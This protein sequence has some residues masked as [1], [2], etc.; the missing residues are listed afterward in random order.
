[1]V[2]SGIC[3]QNAATV[4]AINPSS[5]SP[6]NPPAKLPVRSFITPTYH[7]PKNPPRLPR[8]LIH[9][10]EAAAAVPVAPL[11]FLC[12]YVVACVLL[13]PGSVLTLGA[14]AVFGVVKAFVIVWISATLG[15]TAAFLV[16]RYLARDWVAR[17]IAA[18][19]KLQALDTTVTQD[20]WKIVS[21][22]YRYDLKE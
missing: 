21:K 6:N 5:A 13:L 17:F 18:N 11:V 16:G 1:M 14:G 10:R 8:E 19:P 20:G 12:L 15:A 2:A 22:S 9:A 3:R 7:G 4:A